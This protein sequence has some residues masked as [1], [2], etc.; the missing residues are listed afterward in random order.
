MSEQE[1]MFR[2]YEVVVLARDLPA[3]GLTAGCIGTIVYVYG[4]D[5]TY[6]VEFIDADGTTIAVATVAADDIRPAI[7]GR[8][9][10]R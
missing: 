6:E 3:E 10:G 4:D 7:R 2:E 9:P 1:A 8:E 5:H